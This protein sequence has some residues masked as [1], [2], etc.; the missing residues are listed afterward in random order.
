MSEYSDQHYIPHKHQ[1]QK[2]LIEQRYT[3]GIWHSHSDPKY[4]IQG[5]HATIARWH[6]RQPQASTSTP[7]A[8]TSILKK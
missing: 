2:E 8:M 7:T 3:Q 4:F 6:H 1:L 5:D